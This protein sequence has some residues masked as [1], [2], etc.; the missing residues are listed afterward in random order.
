VANRTVW[1]WWGG[2]HATVRVALVTP[3]SY[4]YPGGV[5]RHAEALAQELTAQG[6]E[7]RLLAPYDPDDRLARVLHRGARPEQRPVPDYLIPL[8]RTFGLPMNGAVTNL[9]SSPEAI[10]ILA[11]ELRYGNYDVVHVQEPNVPV[12]SWFAAEA[13]RVPTVATFHAYATS[14]LPN[15]IAA[16]VIGARR[17]YNKLNARIA[18]SE[19]AEWTA[20]RYYGGRYRIVPNGVDLSAARP[21]AARPHDQLHILFIGRAEGRKGLPVLLRAFEALRAAGVDARLTVAGATELEVEPLLL[22]TEGVEIA[23]RVTEEEKW[24][25]LGDAD[26]LCAPSLGGESFGMVLTEAFAS[27]TPV[28]ASRI[29]GYRD[30]VRSRQDGL[31]VPPGDA[32]ELG[33]ALRDLA[34]DPERRQRMARS[35][36]ERADRYAW[37]QVT[38]EVV[39]VYEEAMAQPQPATRPDR[40]ARN[41]GL[42]PAEPGPRVPPRR[43]PSLE[44]KEGPTTRRRRAHLA[45]RGLVV[46]G[47]LAGVGLTALALQRIGLESITRSL[48][49]ATPIWVLTAFAL[50][51]ASLLVRAE[52]WHAIL[53]AALPGIRVRRRDTARGT[54]IGVLMSATMPARL[55]EPSRALIVARRLGRMRDRFPVV[56]GTIVSQTLLNILALVA[57]GAV[58]FA[59]VGIFRGREDALVIATIAPLVLLALVIATPW[60][61]RRGKPSRFQRVQQAAA[62]ARGAM[63]QVR[64]GLKVF[65]SPKLGIWATVMQLTA[66]GIQW[67]ACYLLLVALG[68]DEH[69]GIG[70]AAAVLFAVNVTA[71]LPATPSN[72]GVFQAACVAVLSAYG[73]GKTDALAYGIILQAVEIATAVVLGMPA[74]VREGMTWKDLR[75]RALHASPVQLPSGETAESEA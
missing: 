70:A 32:V 39:E 71:A 13:A 47:V 33:E 9:S 61:L 38:A 75:L 3:Y 50:M 6:H 10:R 30:V 62:I 40:F 65:R 29:A 59:T 12:I 31:L 49:A 41:L 48:L 73:V 66:W 43:I 15:T 42:K 55:G 74:L 35:A 5:G 72:L 54:M 7:A 37:P 52:A 58:M 2:Y 36:R 27:S 25:L 24:R 17:L 69:A 22:D 16:N 26:L 8:G 28:V 1:D 18:V 14:W 63:L 44:V 68:L 34:L 20:R 45:R 4:T 56:L 57:L 53:R 51:C 46:G 60:L 11:R 21:S 64:S 23:G 19:A 67:V